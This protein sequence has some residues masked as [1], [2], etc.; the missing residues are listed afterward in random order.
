MLAL[1]FSRCPTLIRSE[2]T[3]KL[4]EAT[5]MADDAAVQVCRAFI[6]GCVEVARTEVLAE[7]IRRHGHIERNNEA[8]LPLDENEAARKNVLLQL[9]PAQREVIAGVLEECRRGAIHDLLAHLEWL[10]TSDGFRMSWKGID[11]CPIE[12]LHLD[13]I[14]RAMGYPWPRA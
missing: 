7:R 10:M 1:S 5:T 9:D 2:R 11:I 14:G 13:F 12:T 4:S 8:T 3:G 6:D